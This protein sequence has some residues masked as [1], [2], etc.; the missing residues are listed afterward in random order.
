MKYIMSHKH[1]TIIE[2]NKLEILLKENYKITRIAEILEKIKLL[3]IGKLRELKTNILL[4]KLRKML[5]TKSVKKAETIKL[6]LN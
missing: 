1:F 5:I 6:L 4:R 3:F 2:R